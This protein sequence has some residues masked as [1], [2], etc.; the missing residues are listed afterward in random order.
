MLGLLIVLLVIGVA[1]ALLP[2][3]A[4]I[5][6]VIYVVLAILLIFWLLGFLGYGHSLRGL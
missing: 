5:R 4:R 1:M 6:Q 2:I 3:D